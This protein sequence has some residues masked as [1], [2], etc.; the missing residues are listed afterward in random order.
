MTNARLNTDIRLSRVYRFFGRDRETVPE[1]YPGDVVGIVNPGRIAIGDTLYA[2]RRVEFPRIPQFP[3]EQFATLRPGRGAA[4]ALRRGRV[5]AGR[6]RA[7]AGVH[8]HARHALSDRRRDR[9]PAARRHR[10]A[11]GRRVRHPVHGR[12]HVAR[13]RAL[14]AG[15]AGRVADA[16]D[17]RRAAGRGSAGASG[18]DLRVG[19]GAALHAS[20]RIPRCCSPP[21][22][23]GNPALVSSARN[24]GCDRNA[25]NDGST[26]GI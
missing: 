8:A 11:D 6:G 13:R 16:A 22:R 14:A 3:P 24:L 18:A 21:Q 5:P 19:L 2:D 20:R 15:A 1:A 17:E 26:D 4:Q 7:A 12:P 25:S 23:S 10:G 9:R